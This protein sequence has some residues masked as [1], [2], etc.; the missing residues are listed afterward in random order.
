MP[1]ITNDELKQVKDCIDTAQNY[2]GY[3]KYA[4]KPS[5]SL[6][7]L[8]P[9]RSHSI[10]IVLCAVRINPPHFAGMKWADMSALP[11]STRNWTSI[12]PSRSRM[13]W[14]WSGRYARK[15][16]SKPRSIAWA[17]MGGTV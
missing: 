17:E 16:V 14:K 2:V 11:V 1:Y 13:R 8:W 5:L 15:D 10:P 3:K 9:S 6:T 12:L 7:A 4:E